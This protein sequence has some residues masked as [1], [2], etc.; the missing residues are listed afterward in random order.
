MLALIRIAII[1]VFCFSLVFFFS[2]LGVLRAEDE[3][4]KSEQAE[5]KTEAKS[6]NL[7]QDDLNSATEAKLSAETFN[8]L[9]EVVRLCESAL[10]KGLDEEN[11]QFAKHLLAASLVQRAEVA[12]KMMFGS[13]GVDPKWVDY[14][15]LALADLEKA[16]AMVPEEP[17]ALLMIAKLNLLPG[18]DKKRAEEALNKAIAVKDAET[19]ILATAFIMRAGLQEDP[20]KRLADLDEALR[21][22]PKMVEALRARGFHYATQKKS[23]EALRDLEAA[24]DLDPNH[25]PTIEALALVLSRM[26][27]F[28][29]ALECLD[30]LQELRP[31][32][33]SPLLI[34]ARIYAVK[35]NMDEALKCLNKA[36][37]LQPGNLEVMLL[38][39]SLYDELKQP[40]KALA[41][42]DRVLELKP[43]DE[44][45]RRMRAMLLAKAGKLKEVV[46]ELETI[47]KSTPDDLNVQMQLGMIYSMMQKPAAA[48][49]VYTKILEKQ[50]ENIDALNGRASSYLTLGRHAES[51]ADYEKA[52][53][54][55]CDDSGMLNNFA[56]VL[57]TS[58]DDKLRN[59]KK[60][61]E[62]A[63]KACEMTDYKLA[64]ILSTLAAAYAETGDFESAV[65]WSKKAVEIGE[66]TADE[67]TKKSLADEL[68][69]FESGKPWREQLSEKDLKEPVLEPPAKPEE[70]KPSKSETETAPAPE[71][72]TPPQ[73]DK[74][75]ESETADAKNDGGTES[76]P[77]EQKAEEGK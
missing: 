22:E 17:D 67:D 24:E 53:K 60:A 75:K 18:G 62:L 59:G 56:W 21:L 57:A 36:L 10:E 29:K 7:G 45:A 51:I 55:G 8:D 37:D 19:R 49:E 6:G 11:S 46:A 73:A 2:S 25:P 23:E 16:V 66:K 58:P 42:V 77:A 38:R 4:A 74:E 14:R 70:E 26:E 64:H 12:N 61:V 1:A 69:T 15:R 76:D 48:I 41:D 71:L 44:K 54:L 63:T 20:E 9:G 52:E 35:S 31:T 32:L 13:G 72:Q 33:V 27:Q 47:L 68:K 40:Q 34:K 5:N 39:A 3:T 50:P 30:K 43:D 65:K 28:D